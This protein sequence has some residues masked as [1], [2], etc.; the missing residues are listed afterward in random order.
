MMKPIQIITVTLPLLLVGCGAT[1]NDYQMEK[2]T[3]V[4]EEFFL[5]QL[6]A[7]GM[8][9]DRN[10]KVVRRFRAD[11]RAQW[12]DRQGVVDEQFYFADGETQVRCWRLV[13]IGNQYVGTADDVIGQ[14]T[15]RVAGNA[16]NWRYRLQIPVA[17]KSWE[18]DLNDWMYLVDE[19]NLLNR[20]VI[21]KFG[22]NV[23]EITL[24]IRRVS[25]Q[26]H[27]EPSQGCV[28]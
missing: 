24:Y 21:S 20:A 10:G 4:L 16:F 26:H 19:D 22:F 15:G 2:P 1:L 25:S 14:A 17:D 3:L 28:I 6:E 7:Y 13:K 23:G 12:K 5:G 18:I 11:I 8:V 27:R 9:Q